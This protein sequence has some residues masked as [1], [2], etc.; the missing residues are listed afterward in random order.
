MNSA[1]L[2]FAEG[3]LAPFNNYASVASFVVYD[4]QRI[5]SIARQ[6]NPPGVVVSWPQSPAPF[7]LQINTNPNLN[8]GWQPASNSVF[9]TNAANTY[10]DII[11]M[12]QTFYRLTLP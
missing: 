3:N 8:I 1:V 7:N 4:S 5:L 6:T 10:T 9:I 12:P 2:S 11:T